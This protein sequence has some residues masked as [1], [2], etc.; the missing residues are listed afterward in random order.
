[1]PKVKLPRLE[2]TV[3]T[4]TGNKNFI[5]QLIAPQIEREFEVV[6]SGRSHLILG[7]EGVRYCLTCNQNNYPENEEYVLLTD[8]KP[9][10]QRL[11]N[12]KLIFKIWI[13]HPKLIQSDNSKV[14]ES[15]RNDFKFIKEDLNRKT[16]GL[17][18]P[19]IGAIYS[20][21][22]HLTVSDETGT[23]V[24]PTGT[25]KTE[26][27]IAVLVAN[28]CK[29]VIITVPSD[30]LRSQIFNKFLTFGLLK[31]F[32]VVSEASL[33]PIVGILNQKFDSLEELDDFFS[34][35]NVIVTTMS[36]VAGSP[37]EHQE[38]IA[39]LCS[40][41]FIDEAHHVK[42]QSWDLFRKKFDKNKVL[43]FTA[44]PFRNDR[45][46]LEGKIIFN[47]PLKK[48]QEQGYFKKIN[49]LPIREY[50]FQ[51]ADKLIAQKAVLQLQSDLTQGFNHILMARCENKM[52]AEE[53]FKLYQEFE[54]F[55]PV[56][57]YSGIANKQEILDS[58]IKGEHRIIVAVNMLGEGFDLPE[59]KI[60]AFHDIRKSLPITL[61]FAGRFTR[62]SKDQE[63][64]EASFIANLADA[65]VEDELAELYAQDSNWNLLLSTLS[66]SEIEDEIN[67][68]EFISGFKNFENSSIPFQNVRPA[69]STVVYKNHTD[70]WFPSN[71]KKGLQDYE[72][73]DY[74][75]FDINAEKKVL[76]IVV[77]QKKDVEWGNFKD[78]YG[79]EWIV[80]IVFWE[81]INNLLFIH[82]SDKSG[83][84]KELAQSI[85]G[86]SAE[87][88]NQINV[89]KAFH[90]IHRVSLQ[91]VGLKEFLGKNIRFRMSVGTD[92]EEALSLAE[93]Q[94]GQKAF[95]FGIGY[96]EGVKISLGCSYKGRIWSYMK[97]DLKEF[98]DWCTKIGNK[99]SDDTIDPNQILRETLIPELISERPK[100]FPVS[101]D[102]D[103]EIYA[104]TETNLKI[105]VGARLYNLSN[106]D[107]QIASP[108]EE[109]DLL[110]EIKIESEFESET[111]VFEMR[112]FEH[113]KNGN[114]QKEF[115]IINRTRINVSFIIGTKQLRAEEF[116]Y[117]FTP[118]IWFADGSALTG[119][120]Y[121][122]LKQLIQPYPSTNIITWDW[123]GVDLS[124]EAQGVIPK[125]EDSIQ[126]K[127]IS[128]LR[129][130]DFDIIYDDDGSGEI[131]DIV[132]IKQ[133]P[134]KLKIHLYHLKYAHGGVI[135]NQV[136][137]FYEVCGQ[138]QKSIHW[139]HKNGFEFFDHLLRRE[140]KKRNGQECSRI[141]KGSK[142]DLERL[143]QIAKK[144]IPIEY[145][146][147][148][149]QPSLSKSNPSQSILTL[150]GV[151]E[152]HLKEYAAINLKVIANE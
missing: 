88:I 119:N 70:S 79:L 132:T 72:D 1:M 57:I 151:T 17:R 137:N 46:R 59:L 150:L 83:L 63:L 146:V 78:I 67:F 4:K 106:C 19:Q 42:A 10:I 116:F 123:S 40:H 148:I 110:F 124:K 53:I 86:E 41:L 25:G 144:R 129:N 20:I 136:N 15:W 36:I 107:F 55:N 39:E 24:M 33:Y 101:I 138:A 103:E 45:Q 75:F 52:R 47:F 29:K 23:V 90:A 89:F 14:I 135:G 112:L 80:T 84:Y 27:M 32:K 122:E 96:E 49:F 69:L 68:E 7:S 22:G 51:K 85:I 54:E 31:Q 149:V 130:E 30:A 18:E 73:C 97:G 5:K 64:G 95:V 143:L 133:Y 66:S 145:E 115:E 118:T 44:T 142:E 108:S 152:N 65:N 113:F 82:S 8:K 125:I 9:T 38:R 102:W 126:Y 131:A 12:M 128:V 21:L 111:I 77:A 62:T 92:V 91:N 100:V 109:G 105:I 61:Q 2:E 58:I 140:T 60:A 139:K 26:T 50:D 117:E 56:V 94:R 6:S 3:W 104:H 28:Q 98:M 16:F 11:E 120:Y 134:D 74:K 81:T 35:C 114:M 93:K 71:F 99:L 34:N 48:A 76:V 121:V 13:K 43:Q 87:I 37:S 147:F 141:E 127:V